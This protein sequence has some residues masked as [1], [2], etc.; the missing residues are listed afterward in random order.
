MYTGTLN[1]SKST[2]NYSI[3]YFVIEK[4]SKRLLSQ[5]SSKN[6]I[7]ANVGKTYKDGKKKNLLI[8]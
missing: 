6:T 7:D 2:N 5:I 1:M 3:K 8:F 4:N